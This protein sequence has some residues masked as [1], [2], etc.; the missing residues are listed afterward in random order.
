MIGPPNVF[1]AELIQEFV[2]S[3]T[4]PE[5]GLAAPALLIA[6]LGYPQLDPAPYLARLETMGSAASPCLRGL[7]STC[8][9]APVVPCGPTSSS[10]VLVYRTPLD[11][12]KTQ[13]YA[14]CRREKDF[15]RIC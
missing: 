1:P 12:Q 11:K 6:R 2:Q 4:G 9:K 7:L 8:L 14:R 5:P 15:R 13:N 3:A 10:F